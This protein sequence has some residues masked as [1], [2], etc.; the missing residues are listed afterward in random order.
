M[1]ELGRLAEEGAEADRHD[2]RDRAVAEDDLVDRAGRHGDGA[3]HGVLGNAHR[4][5]VCLEQ[6]FAG[7]DGRL[8]DY[9]ES[10]FAVP[11]GFGDFGFMAEGRHNR[12]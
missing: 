10:R 6:D 2:G 3:G 1:P 5:E 9:D 11:L 12:K 4:G 7:S 8:H